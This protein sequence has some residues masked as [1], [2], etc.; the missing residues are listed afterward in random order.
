[1]TR[2]SGGRSRR[3]PAITADSVGGLEDVLTEGGDRWI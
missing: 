2:L 1:M 3:V